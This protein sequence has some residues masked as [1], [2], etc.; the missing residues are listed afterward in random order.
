MAMASVYKKFLHSLPYYLPVLLLWILVSVFI[1]FQY[2]SEKEHKAMELDA[3]LQLLNHFLLEDIAKG[4]TID[5]ALQGFKL[6]AGETR[7]TLMTRDGDVLYD[8]MVDANTM[9]N[10]SSRNE[11]IE[12][13]I[14]G[15]GN[16]IRRLSET[17]N[18][19]YFYSATCKGDYIIRSAL[20]Y[21]VSLHN[22]LKANRSIW[23]LV[24]AL[25]TVIT[26]VIFILLKTVKQRNF[27]YTR[28]LEQE[29][30]KTRIKRQLTNNINHELKT[31]VSS[32]QVCLETLINNPNLSKEQQTQMIDRCYQSCQRLRNLLRD[33][34]LITR[35]EE[36]SELIEKES[37]CINDIIDD[38]RAELAVFPQDKRMD[39]VVDFDENVAIM[40][41]ASLLIS[42]FRNLTENAIAYSEGTTITIVLVENNE[43]ECTISF[44]D[45][46]NGVSEKHLPHLFERFYRIDKGRSRQTG[47]TGLGLAIVKHAVL[48]H[49]GNITISN[50]ES[51][52]LKF[53]FTL[54][55][56]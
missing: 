45:D 49:H 9:V 25:T 14:Y 28:V 31:P 37:V 12:A 10:H 47:G 55:K 8:N 3:Q 54:K 46:G 5:K 38:L 19:Q 34:S 23:W 52:G 33:V 44:E 4:Q 17:N 56:K 24:I 2:N 29:E 30:E 1:Y 7:I 15:R 35:I 53:V 27:H 16:T 36:G 50:K 39:I 20:P 21:T 6:P 13:L 48:F 26:I 43:E 40:G 32:I 51:G 22:T 41:N 42:I 18:I 11:V